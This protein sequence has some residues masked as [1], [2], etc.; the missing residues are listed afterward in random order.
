MGYFSFGNRPSATLVGEKNNVLEIAI[1]QGS[2]GNEMSHLRKGY[3]T[4]NDKDG[5]FPEWSKMARSAI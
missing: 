1:I 3:G 2:E 5:Q 4:G